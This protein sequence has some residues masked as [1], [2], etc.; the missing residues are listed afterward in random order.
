[1]G[2][3]VGKVA[4]QLMFNWPLEFLLDARDLAL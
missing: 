3:I 2:P 4:L 1:M